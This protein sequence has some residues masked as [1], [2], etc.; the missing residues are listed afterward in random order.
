MATRD[1]SVASLARQMAQLVK[2]GSSY[3]DVQRTILGLCAAAQISEEESYSR[4]QEAQQEWTVLNTLFNS[5]PATQ[6]QTPVE[7]QDKP[8]AWIGTLLAALSQNQHSAHSSRRRLPDPYR[9]KGDRSEYPG[10]KVSMKSKLQADMEDYPTAVLQCGYMYNRLKGRAQQM[11]TPWIQSHE[12][13]QSQT[14][15]E[16]WKF[17]DSCF[18]D[19]YASTRALDKLINIRQ[20]RRSIREYQVDFEE[21]YLLAGDTLPEPMKMTLFRKGLNLEL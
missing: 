1:V 12:K 7:Q 14:Q 16:F 5:S 18:R 2:N 13:N 19:I 20:G 15:E 4:L 11:A 3:E 9:F 8:P 6:A 10:W 21:Q 17:L